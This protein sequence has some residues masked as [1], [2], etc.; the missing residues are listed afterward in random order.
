MCMQVMRMWKT[1]APVPSRPCTGERQLPG[2][3]HVMVKEGLRFW[4]LRTGGGSA[5]V[6]PQLSSFCWLAWL[7]DRLWLF[8]EVTPHLFWPLNSKEKK[9]KAT[10]N[11]NQTRH[12]HWNSC[13][14]PHWNEVWG[15]RRLKRVCVCVC[16]LIMSPV[17]LVARI[18]CFKHFLFRIIFF[19]FLGTGSAKN[20]K[21]HLWRK[22]SCHGLRV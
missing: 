11:Q 5:S 1:K 14:T 7:L 13:S 15:E 19:G 16:V 20:V 6:A 21:H 3:W 4:I 17:F 2:T 10:S 18:P 8:W 22:R 12:F 9:K